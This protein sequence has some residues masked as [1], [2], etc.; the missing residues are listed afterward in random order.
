MKIKKKNITLEKMKEL[1][2]I[3]DNNNIKRTNNVTDRERIITKSTSKVKINK[4]NIKKNSKL[5]K[6][7]FYKKVLPVIITFPI[8]ISMLTNTLKGIS[9]DGKVT[10]A[11]S[12]VVKDATKNLQQVGIITI[13]DD[14]SITINKNLTEE[15]YQN[16]EISDP[17]IGEA[18]AYKKVFEKLKAD[19]EETNYLA[20]MMSYDNGNQRYTDWNNFYEQQGLLTSEGNPSIK[21]FDDQS[22]KELLEAYNN[23]EI[24]NI[25]KEINISNINKVKVK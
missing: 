19:P 18:Y 2:E 9:N 13:E 3:I 7:F 4:E 8:A 12:I 1:H 20:T 25:I 5:N 21:A 10:A 6:T 16:I 14:G 23:G 15:D 22:K 11:I 24:N 17:S